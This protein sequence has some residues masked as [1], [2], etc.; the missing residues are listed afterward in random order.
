MADLVAVTLRYLHIVFGVMWIGAVFYGVLVLR[1]AMG[2][3]EMGARKETMKKLIPVVVYYVPMVATLTIVF[4]TLL[5]LYTAQFSVDGLVGNR[6]G[7]TIFS[8]LILTLA[9][10]GFGIL[11]VVGG[12]RR[13]LGHLNEESCSHGPEVAGLQ[14]RFNRGQVVVM[15]LS[16]VIIGLMVSASRG[17][18]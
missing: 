15:V 18:F 8:A 11:V 16:F 1:T 13:L 10:F 2:R 12:A 5:Y 6:W 14:R 3:V 4:G 7:L 17:V 9:T